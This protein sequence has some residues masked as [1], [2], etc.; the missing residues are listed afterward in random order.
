MK[1]L[2]GT[3]I[4]I[5]LMFGAGVFV[6]PFAIAKAGLFWGL[7]H[8]LIA[9][10][11]TIFLLFLYAEVASHTKGKHRLTGYVELILGKRFKRFAFIVIL[12]SYYGTLLAYGLLGGL[13]LSNFFPGDFSFVL[14]LSFFALCALLLFLK[15]GRIALINFYLTIPLFGFIVYLLFSSLPFVELSNFSLSLDSFSVNNAWFLPYGIWLFSFAAFAAIPE[16]RDIFASSSL[17]DF[18]K[19]ISISVLLSAFFYCLFIF[20]IVGISGI[21]TSDDAFAGVLNVLGTRVIL[22]GSIM[23]ILAVFTS[24]LALG[25]DLRGVFHY[26][27]GFSKIQAWFLVVL[28]PVLLFYA[29][30]QNFTRILSLVGSIGIGFTGALIILMARKLPGRVGKAGE[31]FA[32]VAILAAVAYEIWNLFLV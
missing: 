13:F 18:K 7:A 16:T 10:S 24:F 31:V 17:R 9:V 5:G 25:I 1:F 26:D 3:G 22:A 23:G 14:S 30:L 11:L 12:A 27:F 29:G 28:P 2:K 21:N 15:L 8:L 4:I 6:L 20:A 32:V 19:V